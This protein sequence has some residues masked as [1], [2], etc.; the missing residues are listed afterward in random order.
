MVLLQASVQQEKADV[1]RARCEH[2]TEL[3]KHRDHVAQISAQVDKFK[4]SPVI[5]TDVS[6]LSRFALKTFPH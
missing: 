4:V 2:E 6:H 5:I 1:E 3:Q